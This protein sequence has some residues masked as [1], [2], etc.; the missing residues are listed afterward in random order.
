MLRFE[1]VAKRHRRAVLDGLDLHVARGEMV[2]VVGPNGCG[3]T[4]LLRLAA[5]LDR[6][7]AGRVLVDGHDTVSD[8]EAARTALGW[9]GDTPGLFAELT[10]R[11]NLRAAADLRGQ[12]HAEADAALDAL[13]LGGVADLRAGRL[14]RGWAQRV[15]LAR[16]VVGDPPLVLL[17]EPGAGLDAEGAARLDALLAAR[18]TAGLTTVLASPTPHP[19]ATRVVRLEGGRAT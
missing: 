17:D 12:P 9:A 19:S 4:T 10:V 18:R 16:A 1:A 8:G 7:T 13:G 2:S 6:P 3:K 11:A 5:T 15:A 14:S